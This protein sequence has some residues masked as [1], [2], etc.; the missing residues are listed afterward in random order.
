MTS[1]ASATEPGS[2]RLAVPSLLDP[3]FQAG[4]P[5]PVYRT[6]RRHAP[7]FPHLEGFWI[8]TRHA[9]VVSIS[10]DPS[11]FCSGRGI[12]LA[13]LTRPLDDR[14]ASI[15]H[16]DPPIHR[17]HRRLVQ[18]ALSRGRVAALE[19]VVRRLARELLDA[20]PPREAFDFV[21]AFSAPFPTLVIAE[22][23]GIP[24][25]DRA[26]FRRW[27]DAM[28]ES[29]G[30]VT[31]ETGR[32]AGEI[33]AYFG[34]LIRER[35][36]RPG[37]DLVSQIASA[38]IDGQHLDEFDALMFCL[39]L[40][41]AGNETTRNLLS[42]GLAILA[43]HPGELARLR[44][45]PGLLPSA[46]EEMLRYESP[47]TSFLRTA[48]REVSLRGQRIRT[49]ERVLLLYASANRDEEVF[50]S[51]AERFRVDRQ[52]N[53]HLAFGIGEHFCLG[54]ALARLEARVALADLLAR[55]TQVELAGPGERV[56][57]PL[58]RGFTKLPLF[59][60]P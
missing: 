31:E 3:K 26:L 21:D 44:E 2:P 11:A 52:P 56:S 45:E 20:I 37:H 6:L 39:T 59:L 1:A 48:T 9:D 30:Q 23:L 49:G 57:S 50:G 29:A 22:L 5:Y 46:V 28:I 10:R 35:R 13:D 12:V 32:T 16:M 41:V 27:S 36:H 25:S 55:F 54:A 43:A 51:D 58:M 7:L 33:F 14:P 34:E 24:G 47:I 4:D 42:N 19:P 53:P 18:P 40:L 60:S 15:L 8:V 17:R 38:E